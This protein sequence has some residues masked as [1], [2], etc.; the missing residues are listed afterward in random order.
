MVNVEMSIVILHFFSCQD[1]FRQIYSI[2]ICILTGI[3]RINRINYIKA[4]KV[5]RHE[6]NIQAAK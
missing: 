3:D 6:Q 4:R 1:I 5:S 2:G